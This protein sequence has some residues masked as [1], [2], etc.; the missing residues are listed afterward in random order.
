M[1][2]TVTSLL[3]SA[4]VAAGAASLVATSASG[5]EPSAP[6]PSVADRATLYVVQGVDAATM[7]LAVDGRVVVREAVEKTVAGPYRLTPGTHTVTATP[8]SG[9]PVRASLAV[10]A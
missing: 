1:R 2:R 3:V 5:A 6:A 7:S 10:R 4:L 9:P 8:T